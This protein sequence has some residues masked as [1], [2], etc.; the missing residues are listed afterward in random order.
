MSD[1]EGQVATGL[2]NVR[3]QVI[4]GAERIPQRKTVLQAVTRASVP[5][6]Q[7]A[8]GGAAPDFIIFTINIP[9]V[10]AAVRA[11][12]VEATAGRDFMQYPAREELRAVRQIMWV[13][14]GTAPVAT[15]V[16]LLPAAM[17]VV[18]EACLIEAWHL[19]LLDQVSG[20]PTLHPSLPK[21]HMRREQA[22]TRPPAPSTGE[23]AAAVALSS[24]ARPSMAEM[25]RV[26]Q[27]TVEK[28]MA[29]AVAVPIL[30]TKV[31]AVRARRESYI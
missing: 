9:A 17:A 4:H 2:I 1:M 21:F 28:V 12:V 8:E 11:A 19:H 15:P 3:S 20:A 5:L 14:A 6:L 27:T 25:D 23:A 10:R 16:P 18:P 29:A 22:D 7:K 30:T 24:T 26:A 13:P 31:S